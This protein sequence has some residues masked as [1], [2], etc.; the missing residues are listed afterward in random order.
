MALPLSYEEVRS[1]GF[2]QVTE[3][4]LESGHLITSGLFLSPGSC[5]WAYNGHRE[6]NW[7]LL[8]L[9]SWCWAPEMAFQLSDR[10]PGVWV[11]RYCHIGARQGQDWSRL[12]QGLLRH[13][14]NSS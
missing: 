3:A 11:L 5:L 4:I 1:S 8:R 13:L 2:C 9:E 14:G 7:E 10:W 6:G 12:G